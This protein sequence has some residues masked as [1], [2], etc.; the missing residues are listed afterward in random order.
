MSWILIALLVLVGWTGVGFVAA[1]LFFRVGFGFAARSDAAELVPQAPE[2]D[3]LRHRAADPSYA[4]TPVDSTRGWSASP[5]SGETRSDR[6]RR[7]KRRVA[8]ATG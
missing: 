1:L 8:R 6:D 2:P 5:P 7:R 4:L 3:G